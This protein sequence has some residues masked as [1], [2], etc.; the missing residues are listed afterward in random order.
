MN[1]G[2]LLQGMMLLFDTYV[3]LIWSNVSAA[4]GNNQDMAII[5]TA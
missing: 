5:V 1:A 2:R 3:G 4:F